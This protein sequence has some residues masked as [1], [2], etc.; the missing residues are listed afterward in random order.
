VA[1]IVVAFA[2]ALAGLLIGALAMVSIAAART[3][4]SGSAGNPARAPL[5]LA[6]AI[7]GSLALSGI[8]ISWVILAVAVATGAAGALGV[9]QLGRTGLPIPPGPL[10]LSLIAV[11]TIGAAVSPQVADA[12]GGW[13]T[14]EATRPPTTAAPALPTPRLA[15]VHVFPTGSGIGSVLS[16][17]GGLRCAVP[18]ET[19]LPLGTKV[20]LT[21]QPD[22]NSAFSGWAGACKGTTP[23]CE[24]DLRSAADVSAEFVRLVSVTVSVE[25][26]GSLGGDVG[27]VRC[28]SG[29]KTRVPLDTRL[30]LVPTPAS[31]TVFR[32]W[33]GAGCLGVGPCQVVVGQDLNIAALFTRPTLTASV[34]GTGSGRIALVPASGGV[35]GCFGPCP[36][37]PPTTSYPRGTTLTFAPIGSGGSF[38]SWAGCTVVYADGRCTVR[39]D[40]DVH[41]VATFGPPQ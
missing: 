36:S 41:I 30:N 5:I 37:V 35:S 33:T 4:R 13:A 26:S 16:D 11:G 18:C 29:C 28:A 6:L 20:K 3:G 2:Q 10:V 38:V 27:Q 12:I 32:G 31:D 21:A 17:V 19:A 8:V 9:V 39:L 34:S 22:G 1:E 23:T 40:D 7:V 15:G 24:V 14:P 25:G